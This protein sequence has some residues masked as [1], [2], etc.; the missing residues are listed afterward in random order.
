[1]HV[2]KF[3]RELLG[4]MHGGLIVWID[5]EKEV[6]IVIADGGEIVAHHVADHLRFAP[7]GDEDRDAAFRL[8]VLGSGLRLGGLFAA[9]QF[10][11][12]QADQHHKQGN[13]IVD[14]AGKQQYG[15]DTQGCGDG[16]QRFLY[17]VRER[18][19][20]LQKFL[21]VFAGPGH[22]FAEWSIR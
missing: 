17:K 12:D 8:V 13:E 19:L 15:E 11:A 3:G 22:Y 7:A 20:S 10:A 5:A 1:M 16:K 4:D 21:R 2:R 14:T 18:A 6:E 9:Q